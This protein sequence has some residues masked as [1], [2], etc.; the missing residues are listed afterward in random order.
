MNAK[1]IFACA[2][3]LAAAAG[4]HAAELGYH[5]DIAPILREYCVGCHNE[6]DYDG[7]FSV[8]T[9]RALMEGGESGEAV[10][11]GF[12][13]ETLLKEKKIKMPPEKEPQPSAAQIAML[14]AW[15]DAGATGPVEADDVSMLAKLTV[16]DVAAKNSANQPITAAEFSP[17]GRFLAVARF[18]TVELLD[19]KSRKPVRT[20]SGQEGKVNAV[21]FSQDGKRLVTASGITGLRG[22]ATIWNVETGEKAAELS[23]GHGDILFD[24]EFSPTDQQL[25]ATAGYDLAIRL[26]D[27]ET[28][29][30]VRKIDGHNGAVFDL[31]FSPD[32]AILASAS[33][34]E[35]IKLWKVETGER[36]DTLNQPQGEQFAV[37]FTRDGRHVVGAGADNRIRIWKL[38]SR[39]KPRINPMEQ[40]R[41][42]HED[43]IVA[44]A[45]S[46]DGKR[47]VSSSVDLT[48]K[49]WSLPD[50]QPLEAFARQPE[51]TSAL[52]FSDADNLVAARMDG[53]L[54][55][56]QLKAGVAAESAAMESVRS[57]GSDQSDRS[58]VETGEVEPNDS[59]SEA[60]ALPNLPAR[61]AGVIGEAGDTDAFWFRAKAGE[62]WV[63]EVD[64]A[65]SKSPLDSKVE[66]L[67]AD[68]EPIERAVL[69]A[70]RDSWFTFRGKDSD[71]SDDFRVQNWAE[72]ELNEFLYANGEVV[73][74]WHYPRGPDSGF[75][76]YPGFG[77]RKT[78]FDTTAISHPLGEPCYIVRALP[79]GTQPSP[80]GLPVYRLF[81]ENDDEADRR[82]GKDSQLHF[83]APADGDYV[84]RIHDVR[85]FGGEDFTYAMTIRPRKPDFNI[86]IGGS[87]PA[88]SPGSGKEFELNV[89]RLDDFEGEIRVD[90]SG[91]P[92]GFTA[93]TPIIIQP[94]QSRAY[95]VINAALDAKA[96]AAA[97]AKLSKLVATATIRGQ[98]VEREIGSLGEI[99][100]GEPV[101]LA[102]EILPDGDSG[103][104]V[105][106][107]GKP[108]EFTI[109]PGETITARIKAARVDFKE[110]IELGGDDAGRN[111]P[112]GVY[113]DN[114]GLNGLLI[115][116]EQ[117][118]RQFFITAAPWVPDTSRMFH[119]KTGADGGQA[120]LPAIL[121]VRSGRV[122]ERGE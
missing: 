27:L 41:F 5:T 56:I 3:A 42:A 23:E 107:P 110:R 117:T 74:L 115:V 104:V 83:T 60:T 26:W 11:S 79:P 19:A 58:I 38:V 16:P 76:V 114:I 80:N 61:I 4:S 36:L 108:L 51:L 72:M 64:A 30:L 119:I 7:D 31:A 55:G 46:P 81:Y 85:G 63:V 39:E 20:F 111:L 50:L 103:N 73:K 18:K 10:K 66:I 69:Q 62:E 96:P 121:H 8:E 34:D 43:D 12:F 14:K 98:K 9:F 2:C 28:G 57:V 102:I 109:A 22:V 6:R 75:K 70:V 78:F 122:A 47:L 25:L 68:G 24:A 86:T 94:G 92:T 48:L 101:K 89:E 112:H 113:V 29:K 40:A 53:S 52:A 54:E 33:G 67:S 105:N 91:L 87:A 59:A 106:E 97:D 99:K 32:G 84:A 71:T 13:M 118:E 95:G 88:V 44:M 116:E 17:D 15:I 90:L 100:L 82:W 35:T 45:I 65:R 120:T 37:A 49:S 77:N 93:S 1:L 21:H